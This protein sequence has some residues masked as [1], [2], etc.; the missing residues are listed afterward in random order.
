MKR[1]LLSFLLSIIVLFTLLPVGVM[2]D[3]EVD[4]DAESAVST[5]EHTHVYEE[6][7]IEPTCTEQGY[8]SYVCSCG[9]SYND[10][11]TEALGHSFK[12]QKCTVCGEKNPDYVPGLENPFNDVAKGKYYYY[13]VLWAVEKKVT[14][15]TTDSTFSPN[16]VCNRAQMVTFLWRACG[17]PAPKTTKNVFVDVKKGTFYYNAVLWAV[18]TGVTKGIDASHFAPEREVSRGQAV[19]FLYRVQKEPKIES[20][21]TQFTDV[22]E[23]SFCGPAVAW[24]SKSG[25]TLGVTCNTFEPNTS[26]TRAQIVTFLYRCLIPTYEASDSQSENSTGNLQIEKIDGHS[27]KFLIHATGICCNSGVQTVSV[28]IWSSQDK[29]NIFWY[30]LQKV[31]EGTYEASGNIQNHKMSFGKYSTELYICTASDKRIHLDSES[32]TIAANNFLYIK[33]LGS[34]KMQLVLLGASSDTSSVNFSLKKADDKNAKSVWYSGSKSGSTYTA[35]VDCK[36]L[37]AAGSY[38]ATA[39]KNGKTDAISSASMNVPKS[40]VMSPIQLQIY[41]ATEKVYQTK[42]RDLRACFNY[43]ASLP[44]Y[45]PTP[46]PQKGYTN[47]EWYALYG[48][49]N[50]KGHCYVQAAVFYWLAKNLGYEC[51]YVQGYVPRI[52]GGLITHG[53]VEIIINGTLYV[54]DPNFTNETGRNGYMITYGT[55]GTWYYT[56]YQRMA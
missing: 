53:W 47:S 8:T 42:G 10:K 14:K 43:A 35:T 13:P 3:N 37:S 31:S 32:F 22:S 38:Y 33:D 30:D 45:R 56:K 51:Y 7:I 5:D 39:Y 27:G 15:G 52:G 29:S 11:Y 17:S 21:K 34:G 40:Y 4:S 28:A 36:S 24:A 48:F 18:E 19:T 41:N 1:R 6:K 12:G 49:N 20:N 55:S 50:G 25:V 26:C 9:D 54:C 2:A 23:S 16:I 44:Y 46:E